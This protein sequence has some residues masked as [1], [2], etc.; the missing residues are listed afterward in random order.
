MF[1]ALRRTF[2]RFRLE[3][4]V[5]VSGAAVMTLEV[6]GSR[7]I[8]PYVG[9]STFI[10]TSLI[11]V[12]MLALSIGYWY[13]GAY[14]DRHASYASLSKIFL[15]ASCCTGY[16]LFAEFFLPII[17]VLF[18]DVR[19]AGVV[20]GILVFAPAT[21]LLGIVSPLAARLR[22]NE[23]ATA[24]STV[25]RLYA[26]STVGSIFGTFLGGF[27]LISYISSRSIIALVG[28]TL[29]LLSVIAHRN[30]ETAFRA[31][32]VILFIVFLA[33]FLH[34]PLR[35]ND[36]VVAEIESSYSR[37]WVTEMKDAEGTLRTLTNTNR[38]YQS[39]MKVS[40]PV[41]LA[42][43][44][45]VPIADAAATLPHSP[46][47]ILI[48]GA[49]A[50]SLPKYF[51]KLYPDARQTIVEIDPVMTDI[52]ETYFSY[53]P[54]ANN[55]IIHEDARIFLNRE[56][57]LDTRYDII[58]IDTYSAAISIPF[59]MVTSEALAGI[60]KLAAD[61]GIVLF[62]IISGVQ[63][64]KSAFFHSFARTIAQH[65]DHIAARQVHSQASLFTTQNIIL[66]ASHEPLP[67][68]LV[69]AIDL[70]GLKNNENIPLFTDQFAPV[71]LQTNR[72]VN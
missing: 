49:G 27:I 31:V 61:D 48:L 18:S 37:M 2:L 52:A 36:S 41:A 40:D 4:I 20:A 44:Y 60:S 45:T 65:F 29:A 21:I 30:R 42:A 19:I 59:H 7:I 3:I 8:A 54:T 24:G 34:S 25:G 26:I 47:N 56:K 6:I 35:R 39:A 69:P 62:N 12:F 66:S 32:G 63:G 46:K 57:N 10:W 17:A 1:T 51:N 13:G 9:T 33:F 15:I 64:K 43:A 58:V 16:I 68:T 22:L 11:G 55:H 70:A 14:A 50:Y 71:E 28:I 67:A 5:C 38:G 53:E 23:L 72:L